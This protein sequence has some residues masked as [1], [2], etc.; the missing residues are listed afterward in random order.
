MMRPA[1]L[2]ALLAAAV[3]VGTAV[4]VSSGVLAR[5]R[6]EAQAEA[7]RQAAQS[8]RLGQVELEGRLRELEARATAAASLNPVRAVVSHRLDERTLRDLFETEEWWRSFR[9]EFSIQSIVLGQERYDFGNVALGKALKLEPLVA[10]ASRRSPTSSLLLAGTAGYLCTAGIVDVPAPP[11]HKPAAVILATPFGPTDASRLAHRVGGAVLMTSD[12]QQLVASG[13]PAEQQRRLREL[14]AQP[15][16]VLDDATAAASA[17][18]LGNG[19]KLWVYAETGTIAEAAHRSVL[20]SLTTVWIIAALLGTLAVVAAI[21]RPKADRATLEAT[22]EELQRT[23]AELDRLRT[24]LPSRVGALTLPV[25][26]RFGAVPFG[27]YQ[28]LQVL[29]EGGMAVVHLAVAHGAEGFRRF[30]V[31]KRLR[32]EVAHQQEIVNQFINEARVGASLVHSNIVPIY[33]FGREGEE[34]FLAQEYILGRD[35]SVLVRRSRQVDGRGLQPT[36]VLYVAQELLKALAYAHTRTDAAGKSLGIVH[37]DIS[38]M[39][40]MISS[41]GEVKLLDFGIAKSDRRIDTTRAGVVKGNVLFMSP[42]QARGVETDGRSDLFSLGLMLYFCLTG[43]PLYQAGGSDY[44][45]LVRAAHGPGPQ[46]REKLSKLPAGLGELLSRVLQTSLDQRFQTAEAFAAALPQL[47]MAVAPAG[48]RDLVQR[49]VGVELSEEE[50]RFGDARQAALSE[51]TVDPD[52]ATDPG[53]IRPDLSPL[54][55]EFRR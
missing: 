52:H 25:T 32:Q 55:S 21:R 40:V 28:L 4:F 53:V 50:K 13:G 23:Q 1:R 51:A 22:R 46:E 49:L 7:L 18:S 17:V 45:L 27:R 16:P 33:D 26:D 31:V 41:D 43:E 38:P 29:G 30:F 54:S 5:A 44:D 34:Y 11:S 12:D 42:E 39:N 36:L 14:V 9:E 20:A 48:L 47:G 10:E 2:G 3:V 37:R 6:R 19:F 15:R 8:A 35:L 24:P